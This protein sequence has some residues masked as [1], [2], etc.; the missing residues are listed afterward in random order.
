MKGT[1]LR[2]YQVG[3][4]EA[5][6][7]TVKVNG[8]WSYIYEPSSPNPANK[9]EPISLDTPYIPPNHRNEKM[10]L[11][12]QPK[13]HP[14][15]KKLIDQKRI[16]YKAPISYLREDKST[17]NLHNSTIN[18]NNPEFLTSVQSSGEIQYFEN[19]N[20]PTRC[21]RP[22]SLQYPV[23]FWINKPCDISDIRARTALNTRLKKREMAR[24]EKMKNHE[25]K[26]VKIRPITSEFSN[27]QQIVRD[28]SLLM[29]SKKLAQTSCPS[30]PK[31]QPFY[32]S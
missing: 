30:P 20:N 29:E 25:S 14:L 10:E 26:K 31:K 7:I 2:L 4:W 23:P 19:N 32:T 9:K 15:H 8:R 22:N 18:Q 5:S 6:K 21:S 27:S 28:D 16:I 24:Q 17:S 12:V 11:I 13:I 3:G 1:D